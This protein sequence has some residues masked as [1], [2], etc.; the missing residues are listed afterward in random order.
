MATFFNRVR[1]QASTAGTVA[2]GLG[3]PIPGYIGF[4]AVPDQTQINY[5]AVASD[6]TWEIGLGQYSASANTVS[7]LNVESSSSGNSPVNFAV[8]PEVG[9]VSPAS[10][11]NAPQ[12]GYSNFYVYKNAQQSVPGGLESQVTFE[13]SL[14]DDL[15]EFDYGTNS[16]V[17]SEAGTYTFT[18]M[19]NGNTASTVIKAVDLYVNGAWVVRLYQSNNEPGGTNAGGTSGPYKLAAGDSVAVYYY[20]SANDTLLG[21]NPAASRFS[22]YRIR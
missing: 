15:G 18:S 1:V 9:V 3:P 14:F 17:A 21:N 11:Y 10:W 20:T 22:G 5:L 16:F 19:I 4:G 13:A 6:G 7:R 2:F 8:A 12:A